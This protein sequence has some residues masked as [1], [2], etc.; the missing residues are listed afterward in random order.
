[1]PVACVAFTLLAPLARLV[2]SHTARALESDRVS[3]ENCEKSP[4][5]CWQ[6]SLP[7]PFACALHRGRLWQWLRVACIFYYTVTTKQLTLPLSHCHTA[8]I[9]LLSRHCDRSCHNAMCVHCDSHTELL[10]LEPSHWTVTL[11]PSYC[12]DDTGTVILWRSR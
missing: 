4:L 3:S 8:A 1:M 10:T 2:C 6:L 9:S 7:V 12:D 11:G 5:A